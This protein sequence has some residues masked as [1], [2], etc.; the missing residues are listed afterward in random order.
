MKWLDSSNAVIQLNVTGYWCQANNTLFSF[1]SFSDGCVWV[2]KYDGCIEG[3][4]Y[5][6]DDHIYR[7]NTFINVQLSSVDECD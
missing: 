1:L 7:H 3:E 5:G 6:A 4:V 2:Y